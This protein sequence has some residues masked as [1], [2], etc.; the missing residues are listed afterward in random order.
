[1]PIDALWSKTKSSQ[2]IR[3]LING[4]AATGIHFAVLTFNLKVLGWSSAGVANLVA[5]IFGISASFLGSR[6]FVFNNSTEALVSQLYRFVLLYSVIALLHGAL[7]YVWVDVY[8]LNYMIGFVI[9]TFMQVACSY[10]GNK[11]MVFKV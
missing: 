8:A 5:A 10:L 4:L 6:Y 9:A 7:L 2:P 1:M 11:V 3:Y